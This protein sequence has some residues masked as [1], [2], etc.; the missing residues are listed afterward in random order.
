MKA[1][2][3]NNTTVFVIASLQ[4]RLTKFIQEF[5]SVFFCA[6]VGR[7]SQQV[8]APP[9]FSENEWRSETVW[10]CES[11]FRH[12]H[13]GVYVQLAAFSP[14]CNK[15]PPPG[16]AHRNRYSSKQINKHIVSSLTLLFS[17]ICH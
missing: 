12:K 1:L 4:Q 2:G 14:P 8:N 9:P 17:S 15:I 5:L 7:K 13:H 3:E 10:K 11:H 16:V 6:S